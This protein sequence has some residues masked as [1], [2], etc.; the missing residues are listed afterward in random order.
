MTKLREKKA[1]DAAASVRT[2]NKSA[3]AAAAAAAVA[4]PAK[5]AEAA[6]RYRALPILAFEFLMNMQ[7]AIIR[8]T[9]LVCVFG[10]RVFRLFSC[11]TIAATPHHPSS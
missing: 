5:A 7:I 11:C 2:S 4:A 3:S 10:S 6:A 8:S 1:K 9:C